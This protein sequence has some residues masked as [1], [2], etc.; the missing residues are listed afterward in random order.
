MDDASIQEHV[1]LPTKLVIDTNEDQILPK[2]HTLIQQQIDN[3]KEISDK[4]EMSLNASKTF[5]LINNFTQNYQF[6]P[7]LQI[8]GTNSV[9]ET[10]NETKLLGYWLTSDVKPHR[11]V[12]HILDIAYKRL[13]ALAKLKKAGVPDQDILHF[14]NVKIRSV[15][16]SNCPVFHPMLTQENKDDI[17][18]IQK[19]VL[20]IIMGAEYF[21]YEDSCQ[22]YKVESLETRRT[23]LSLN[24]A[25]KCTKNEKFKHMFELNTGNTHEKYK[26]PFAHTSRYQNSPKIFLTKLLNK[27]YGNQKKSPEPIQCVV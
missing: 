15:L 1:D 8:P 3:I 22:K 25:L 21:S 9:I 7:H 23:K 18:R 17:E 24:F 26:V 20:K 2:E 6:K 14:F 13:W 16:E 27:H 12:K 10:K 11:H 19:I 4:R 5:L